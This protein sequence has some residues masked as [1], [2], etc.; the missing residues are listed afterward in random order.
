MTLAIFGHEINDSDI[1]EDCTDVAGIEPL[2]RRFW[3][4]FYLTPYMLFPKYFV[5][6]YRKNIYN[7]RYVL[8]YKY[9]TSREMFADICSHSENIMKVIFI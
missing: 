4:Q 7:E 5:N 9:S 3:R 1:R 6:N 8:D 2:K